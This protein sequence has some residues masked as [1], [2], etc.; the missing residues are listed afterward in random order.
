MKKISVIL[1]VV[2]VTICLAGVA[3]GQSQR[4][5]NQRLDNIESWIEN[6]EDRIQN[7]EKAEELKNMAHMPADL[8]IFMDENDPTEPGDIKIVKGT[9]EILDDCDSDAAWSV[10]SGAGVT[11]EV[12]NSQ[13]Y[14]GTGSIKVTVPPST[15]AVIKATKSAG[16]WNLT[17]YKYLRVFL[18]H[19]TPG[20][21]P[22]CN[23]HFGEGAYNEQNFGVFTLPFP[24]WVQKSW[25]ISGIPVASKNEVTI[26]AVTLPNASAFFSHIVRID[27][28]FADPGPSQV[29]A[30][31]GDRVILLYP[32]FYRGTYVGTGNDDLSVLIPR[33]GTPNRIDIVK[34][35]GTNMVTWIQGMDIGD[36]LRI[37]AATI[38]DGIKTISD[39]SFTVGV[40]A[41]VNTNGDT[42]IFTCFWDD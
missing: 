2:A 17:N 13:V 12:D 10:E 32:K 40:N 11:I 28:I 9:V 38:T 37:G 24:C 22:N 7:I 42:H 14:E 1:L 20:Y 16:V 35:D 30:F 25:D 39:G 5:I 23:L 6:H 18:Y 8:G 27:Y 26:F 4:R 19:G 21:M 29:K 36:S 33:K 31:D 15:T 34:D 41:T 3:F